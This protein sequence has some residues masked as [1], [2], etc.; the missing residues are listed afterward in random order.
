MR[1]LFVTGIGT[2]IGKTVVSAILTE[3]L[4][5]DYWKPVQCGLATIADSEWVKQM[6]SN[7]DSVIH[8]EAYS[9]KNPLSPHA[10]AALENVEI[11]LA[12]ITIPTSSNPVLIIEGAGGLMVPLNDKDLIVDLIASLKAEVIVV[13]NFYLGSINHTLLT[14]SELKRRNI[15]VTG[16]VFNGTFNQ[17]S[18][19]VILKQ[20]GLKHLGTIEQEV[21]LDKSTIKK[22]SS[23]FKNLI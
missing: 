1:K 21:A 10:A 20:T 11:D 12:K 22:Y 19:T 17:A 16:I 7:T 23:I 15:S 9:F 13:S 6:V 8:P 2:D 18:A 5:G 4:K 14:C 3:S